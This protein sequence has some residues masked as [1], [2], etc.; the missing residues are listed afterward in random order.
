MR[1]K[2]SFER[3]MAGDT[4]DTVTSLAEDVATIP[5]GTTPF[6]LDNWG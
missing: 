5:G 3:G 4:A 2:T 6:G 1:D